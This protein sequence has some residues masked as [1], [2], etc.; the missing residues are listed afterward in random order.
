MEYRLGT[1]N[2]IREQGET[3]ELFCPYCEKKVHFSVFSNLERRIALKLPLPID[4][5]TVYFLVCPECASIYSVD[6]SS[7]EGFRNG[8][9]LSIGNFDL[10]ELKDFK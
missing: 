9:K 8:Q 4:V 10:R 1:A 3:T 2:K 5:H 6:E 7:A